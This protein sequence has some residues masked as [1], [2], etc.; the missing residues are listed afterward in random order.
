MAALTSLFF[1]HHII[2]SHNYNCN[3]LQ[4]YI[5]CN[6]I[7][8]DSKIEKVGHIFCVDCTLNIID[9]QGDMI[10]IYL[11]MEWNGV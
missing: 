11:E 9:S 10:N 5:L 7:N 8:Q 3:E 6:L 1:I 4:T 2:T